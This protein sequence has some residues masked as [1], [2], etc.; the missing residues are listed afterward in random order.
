MSWIVTIGWVLKAVPAALLVLGCVVKTSLAAA[1]AVTLKALLIAEV[2]LVLVAVSVY[3]VPTRFM[4]RPL[5]VATPLTA[6]FILVPES[7][8]P[9]VPVPGV[10]ANVT[11][12]VEDVIMLP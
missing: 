3:P 12:A 1:P 11:D 8:A 10:I 9:L 5:K 7:T 2:R 6:L 4:L